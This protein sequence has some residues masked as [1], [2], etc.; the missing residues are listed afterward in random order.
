MTSVTKRARSH[1][2][3]LKRR[4]AEIT[5]A[6]EKMPGAS[7]GVS[8]IEQAPALKAPAQFLEAKSHSSFDSA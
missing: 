7:A 1:V 2:A 4:R 5:E 6:A 8:R 3:Q